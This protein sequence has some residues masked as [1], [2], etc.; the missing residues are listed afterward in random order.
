MRRYLIQFVVANAILGTSTAMSADPDA[1]RQIA[2]EVC[3]A[4]H[5]ANGVSVSQRIP[6]LAGQRAAYT[7][8]QLQAYKSRSRQHGIMSGLAGELSDDDMANV[9]AFYANL[10]G[11]Q[12][13]APDS[14]PPDN[15]IA[16]RVKFPSDLSDFTLY[17]TFNHTGRKQLR[18]IYANAIAID[19]AKAGKVLPN[20][21]V[22]VVEIFKAKL[23]SDKKPVLDANGLYIADG[24]AGYTAMERQSGWGGDFPALIRNEDWHYSVFKSDGAP[25]PNVNQASCLACHKPLASTSFVFTL[26]EL[27]KVPN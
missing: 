19:A 23:G 26:K 9:A 8:K 2:E 11:P 4:C 12:A 5:G 10:P 16:K 14:Q 25:R 24:R 13:G 7:K 6:N 1:G 21:S 20:G 18:K 3:S 22:I 17:K 15:F 27:A